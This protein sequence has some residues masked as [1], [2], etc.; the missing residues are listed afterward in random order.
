MVSNSSSAAGSAVKLAM[1]KAAAESNPGWFPDNS[2][3]NR[4]TAFSIC[5]KVRLSG[6]VPMTEILLT[7]GKRTCPKQRYHQLFV[8]PSFLFPTSSVGWFRW[9]TKTRT[10]PNCLNRSR[11]SGERDNFQTA[12]DTAFNKGMWIKCCTTDF[13]PHG[14]GDGWRVW[15]SDCSSVVK[16]LLFPDA[17]VNDVIC[18]WYSPCLRTQTRVSGAFSWVST[19]RFDSSSA[20]CC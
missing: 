6:S 4:G 10:V 12:V 11:A 8:K 3:T 14:D 13:S 1:V 9:R 18:C 7:I 19:F 5:S 17:A 2:H 20:N 15:F 16:L